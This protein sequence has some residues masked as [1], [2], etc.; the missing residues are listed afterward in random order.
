MKTF[1]VAGKRVEPRAPVAD[2]FGVEPIA[3]YEL[4]LVAT[5][6]AQTEA[7]TE[8]LPD[9]HVME[10]QI[11]LPESDRDF[12]LYTTQERFERDFQVN[13]DHRG[14]GM[15]A[16]PTI[17]PRVMPRRAGATER[18]PVGWLLKR[19]GLF[20]GPAAPVAAGLIGKTF[21]D[22]LARKNSVPELGALYRCARSPFSLERVQ[23]LPEGAQ[24][25]L[26]FIHGTASWCGGSFGKLW[27]GKR[28]IDGLMDRYGG[29]V[30]ALEHRTLTES[31]VANAIQLLE[32]LPKGAI[33]HV[34]T[35]SRGGL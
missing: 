30:Y 4:G 25:S 33:L 3:T 22:G 10:L 24:P 9:K 35:H 29:R 28:L 32:S 8:T 2:R 27:L 11:E 17:P 23:Q 16:V 14:P 34:V 31:P 19:L 6:G 7:H 20:K 18:G 1:Q 5:R 26:V 12:V 15:P 21:E 13:E